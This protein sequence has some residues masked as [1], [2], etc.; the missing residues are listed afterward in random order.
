MAV[1]YTPPW[2]NDYEH[3]LLKKMR[4][5]DLIVH[6]SSNCLPEVYYDDSNLPPIRATIRNAWQDAIKEAE[7]LSN[8]KKENEE[9]LLLLIQQ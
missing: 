3:P 9:E 6:S 4:P 7:E 5:E 2:D 1:E 8:S